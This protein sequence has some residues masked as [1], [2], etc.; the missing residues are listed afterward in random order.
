[1]TEPIYEFVRGEG[2]IPRVN[3]KFDPNNLHPLGLVPLGDLFYVLHESY[4]GEISIWYDSTVLYDGFVKKP[5]QPGIY[6]YEV[7][8]PSHSNNAVWKENFAGRRYNEVEALAEV[9]NFI[10]YQRNNW[11]CRLVRIS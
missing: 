11:Y 10:R 5:L 4:N 2:W 9:R 7:W 6:G 8:L 1:M 3:S